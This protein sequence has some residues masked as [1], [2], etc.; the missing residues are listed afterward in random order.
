MVVVDR[1]QSVSPRLDLDYNSVPDDSIPDWG[2][3]HEL[4]PSHDIDPMRIPPSFVKWLDCPVDDRFLGQKI[5]KDLNR[6]GIE[7]I[8]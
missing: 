5:V 6:W 2:Q 7:T 1:H 3:F 4:I 8:L